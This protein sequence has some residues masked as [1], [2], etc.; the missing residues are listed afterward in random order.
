M[1]VHENKNAPSK[2]SLPH[3]LWTS[4]KMQNKARKKIMKSNNAPTLQDVRF[5]NI[6]FKQD[7]ESS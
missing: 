6:C 1:K 7:C 5:W 4:F 3:A 2:I